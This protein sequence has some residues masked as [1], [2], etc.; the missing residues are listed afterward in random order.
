VQTLANKPITD[1]PLRKTKIRISIQDH[2][3]PHQ[4]NDLHP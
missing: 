1:I 3:Q 2:H 4:I